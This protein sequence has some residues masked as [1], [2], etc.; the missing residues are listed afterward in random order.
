MEPVNTV[1]LGKLR[2]VPRFHALIS[3]IPK[4]PGHACYVSVNKAVNNLG[5][6]MQLG[7][8]RRLI[9]SLSS[10]LGFDTLAGIASISMNNSEVRSAFS[11]YF[12]TLEQA[13]HWP[14]DGVVSTPSALHDH[15]LV[16]QGCCTTQN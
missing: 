10:T 11:V 2:T 9:S 15:K 4:G 3:M 14:M 5:R 12:T 16:I 8:H 6:A 1:A 7:Q 13:Y